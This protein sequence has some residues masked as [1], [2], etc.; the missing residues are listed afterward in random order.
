MTMNTVLSRLLLLLLVLPLALPAQKK[1]DFGGHFQTLNTVFI[2]DIRSQWYS[3]SSVYNRLNL[4]WY[5]GKAWTV[6]V[7]ARNVLN[8]GQLVYL[9]YPEYPDLLVRDDGFF[10]LTAA[11]I[12]DSSYILYSNLDRLNLKYTKEKFETT[13]G[14][15]RINWGMNMVWNPNDIFNTFSFY[16]FDY[17]ERPGCD[18]INL[19]YYTGVSSSLQAAAKLDSD[20]EVTAALMYRFNQKGYDFQIMGGLIEQDI[21]AG[22]GWSGNIK[23]AG[24]TGE[25]SWFKNK[26]HLADSAG[27]LILSASI[28]YTFKNSLFIHGSVLFNNRGTTGKAGRDASVLT[29][30][31]MSPKTLTTAKTSLFAQLSYPLSPIIRAD[32]AAIFNPFDR[33]AFIGPNIDFSLTGNIGFL[34]MA[35]VFIGD[36]GTEFGNYGQL[37]HFRLKWSF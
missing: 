13:I 27:I 9:N 23:N 37:Y 29:L 34:V 28:N 11:L 20:R 33:S 3:N 15:Q 10:D 5:A 21:V 12:R 17:I 32:A 1:L 25:A 4:K 35:Q 31:D 26:N 24:F 19:Q 18:A 14:R 16:D 7:G 36:S 2:Q 8:Y 22:A 6:S 30:G